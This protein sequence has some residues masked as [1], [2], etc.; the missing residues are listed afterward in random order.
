MKFKVVNSCSSLYFR[1]HFLRISPLCLPLWHIYPI[2]HCSNMPCTLNLMLLYQ[3]A[4]LPGRSRYLGFGAHYFSHDSKV[5]S[6]W[7]LPRFPQ[8]ATLAY[9]PKV[10]CAYHFIVDVI[11][12]LLF[13]CLSL[14]DFCPYSVLGDWG[15]FTTVL[16]L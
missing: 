16:F 13:S 11:E 1:P 6:L 8:A 15:L 9:G 5:T 12:W 2:S 3:V 10:L 4:S 7:V 14:H